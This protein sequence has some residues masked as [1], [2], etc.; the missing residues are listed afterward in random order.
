VYQSKGRRDPFLQS[1]VA[2]PQEGSE[3]NLKVTGIVRG[4]RSHYALV[5]SESLTGT[6]FVIRENDVVNSARVLKI[7]QDSVIFEVE[8]KSRE[9]KPLTRR[10]QKHIG[11]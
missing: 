3:V 11:L 7:T 8:T 9:G 6:G 4:P 5:E 1:R 2:A 10:V